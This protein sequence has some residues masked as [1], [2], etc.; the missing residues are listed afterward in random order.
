MTTASPRNALSPRIMLATAMHSQPGVYAL[1]LGSG[2][3]TGAGVPTGWGVVA[4]LVEKVAAAD[5]PNDVDSHKFASEDPEG[6]WAA[7]GTGDLG[8]SSLLAA[9]AP[10]PAA[11]QGL[12]QDYF[13]P[14]DDEREQNIKVPNAAHRAIAQLVKRG[15]VKVILTTNFDRLMEQALDAAGIPHQVITRPGAV[16]GMTPLP[17]ASATI[18]KL[19]GDY[20]ELDTRN[21]VD[22]LTEY[23][24]QW[25]ELLSR[26]FADY[27]LLIS[28]WSGDW[29]KA[30]VNALQSA[31][32]RY[33]LYWD[34]RSAKGAAAQ[35]L[36]SIHQG[37]IVDAGSADELFEDLVASVEA[38]EKLAEPP[39]TT[40]IAVAR[41]KRYLPD[42][43]RRI[44]LHDLVMGSANRI[45]TTIAR[46]DINRSD[47]E[48]V[49]ERLEALLAATTPLL[50]LLVAGIHHDDTG[51]GSA[52]RIGDI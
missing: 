9:M 25:A 21:T 49:D 24:D 19:H 20:A 32:R 8:Y 1:L 5:D 42:P 40:A 33:P 7:R 10:T 12:L 4:N 34:S 52:A 2:V 37:H 11:R 29:D 13:V 50:H 36:V 3:S 38:L 35:Q 27:G 16:A 28:G 47:I 14:T 45:A 23:P 31:P 51:V 30:L 15:I 46:L 22:E 39:L 26:I 43:A 18:I 6:W 44:E 17:H 41:L 48:F